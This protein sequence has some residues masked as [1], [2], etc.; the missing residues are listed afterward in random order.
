MNT[1]PHY[2][3]FDFDK[4]LIAQDSFFL[5]IKTGF[6]KQPWRLVFLLLFSPILLFAVLFKW[7][8]SIAK[9]MLL[10]SITCLKS[11]KQNIQ[12][13]KNVVSEKINPIWFDQAILEFEKLRQQNVEIVIISASGNSWLRKSLHSKF[14]FC[15]M[16]IG[17]KL[18]FF[19]SGVIYKS[20]NCYFEEKIHR[21][22][23]IFKSDFIWHSSYSDH[24]ADIPLLRQAPI[25]HLICPQKKHLPIFK[26]QLQGRYTIL[27]WTVKNP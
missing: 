21:I 23:E 27:S 19:A 26:D 2:A 22:Y 8:K 7:D 4:T 16:I 12:F 6:Q 15:R 14:P 17:S 3:F 10:W 24:I 9:S 13:F 1:L 25:R 11:K 20:K 5:L 18:G